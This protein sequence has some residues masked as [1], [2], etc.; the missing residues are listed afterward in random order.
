[1]PAYANEEFADF[2]RIPHG[3]SHG[4]AR[5]TSL[6]CLPVPPSSQA[7]DWV[8]AFAHKTLTAATGATTESLA[9]PHPTIDDRRSGAPK[10]GASGARL[11]LRWSTH[12]VA[13]RARRERSPDSLR[14]P[15]ASGR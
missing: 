1:M 14:S 2:E 3:V 9:R 10:S 6:S 5:F 15:T 11:R 7:L 13:L 4:A 8:G 12:A